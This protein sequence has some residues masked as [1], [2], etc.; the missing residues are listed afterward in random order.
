[1]N[2]PSKIRK[3]LFIFI[4]L[5]VLVIVIIGSILVVWL[6]LNNRMSILAKYIARYSKPSEAN[7]DNCYRA[8]SN[9]Q[10]EA[11][12]R[13]CDLNM[14]SDG[15]CFMAREEVD[16]IYSTYVHDLNI[17]YRA[18][19]NDLKIVNECLLKYPNDEKEENSCYLNRMF[20]TIN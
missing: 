3:L 1:M 9:K 17:C 12:K 2:I 15:S 13:L 7:F 16:K 10:A 11:E 18:R 19:V 5:L 4:T 14:K 20:I 8:V 6:F